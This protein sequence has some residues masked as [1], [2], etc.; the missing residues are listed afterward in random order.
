MISISTLVHAYREVKRTES[1]AEDPQIVLCDVTAE[2]DQLDSLL[3]AEERSRA[4]RFRFD[5]DR[6]RF[7]TARVR[8]RQLLAARLGTDASSLQFGTGA[9]GKP[10]LGGH[11]IEFSFS[12]SGDFVL[13]AI[14]S[15]PV[16]ADIERVVEREGLGTVAVEAFTAEERGWLDAQSDRAAAFYRLWTMKEAALKADG[17]GISAG[18][19]SASVE[20]TTFTRVHL[21]DTAW[22]VREVRAGAE[23]CGA[24]A[25]PQL[26]RA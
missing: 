9:H 4:A 13:I 17:R 7:I 15:F 2:H 6:R 5:R 22:E 12:H 24:V 14:A 3:S 25:W 26:R 19:R 11:A 23:Y 10:F 16:G 1:P 21:G 18:L 8:L 20:T